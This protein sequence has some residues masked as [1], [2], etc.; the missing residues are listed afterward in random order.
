MRRA[1]GSVRQTGPGRWMVQ[2]TVP[3]DDGRQHRLTRRVNG[4]RMDAERRLEDLLA[5][6]ALESGRLKSPTVS[7][8]WPLF[9]S[10]CEDVR[11]LSD[12]T[13][14]GY[15]K[16]YATHIA[17][18]FGDR[19][20]AS[21]EPG[22]VASWL[23]SMTYGAARSA[24]AVMGSF[25]GW[26][27]EAALVDTNVMRRRYTLPRKSPENTARLRDPSIY[28]FEEMVEIAA[29]CEGESWEPVF[30]LMAF[31][32]LRRSEACAI[33][34]CDIWEHG[35]WAAIDVS[36]ALVMVDNKPVLHDSPKTEA[37]RRTAVMEPGPARRLLA[38][39]DAAAS[40]GDGWMTGRD[41]P[42]SPVNV[43]ARWSRW[44][45][46]QP[47]RRI[48]LANL[49]NSYTTMMIARGFD[50][51]MV[52]KATGHASLDVTYRNYLRPGPDDLIASFDA[53]SPG[54]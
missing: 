39:R 40:R 11:R 45:Q 4:T 54:S 3:S 21:I 33:R 32:G 19:R 34:P 48:P 26:A 12:T 52:S 1:R 22:E 6:A 18:A 8:A 23:A 14:E 38:L 28:T 37:S 51:A 31:A 44:F 24:R 41:A 36:K 42:E 2:A 20:M 27:E 9:V 53:I 16:V 46:T 13:I 5:E 17:P 35:E 29:A 43:A 49:R 30:L 47:F 15:R 10:C 25:Y 7:E 50:S